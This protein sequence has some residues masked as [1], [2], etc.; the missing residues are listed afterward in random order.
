MT[1]VFIV[2]W[3]CEGS[4][5]EIVGVFTSLASAEKLIKGWFARDHGGM[6]R[7]DLYICPKEVQE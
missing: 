5:S 3:D 4:G 6:C 1:I 7:S 2:L